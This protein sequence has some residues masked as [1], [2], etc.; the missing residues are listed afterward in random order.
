MGP[1]HTQDA[2]V[3][4]KETEPWRPPTRYLALLDKAAGDIQPD[5]PGLEEWFSRYRR[6]HTPRLA[7]DLALIERQAAPDARVL[8]YGAVPLLVTAAL[9]ALDYRVSAL[10]VAPE[11]FRSTIDRLNLDVRAC[12]IETTAVPFPSETFDLVVFNEVFEHLRINPILTMREAHRVL[13][14]SGSLLLSTPNLR[15]LRGLRNLLLHNQAHAASADVYRQYE[16]L[17]TLGHMGH[18]RE[19]TTSEVCEFLGHVGFQAQTIVYRGGHGAGLVGMVER[20]VP[21]LRPF[22][23]LIATKQAERPP[24]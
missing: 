16:K 10:D 24:G 11:R 13:K 17:E 23:T 20:L 2:P 1:P 15:S 7:A 9:S 5:D 18:V 6:Q 22:F 8:E 3:V 12:D 19:Y 21:Q 4:L 14:R